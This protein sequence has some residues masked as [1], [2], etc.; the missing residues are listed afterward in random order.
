VRNGLT[1]RKIQS[2]ESRK[3]IF[4]AAITLIKKKGFDEVTIE[5]ICEKAKVSKGL[6]YNYFESKDQII[7]DEFLEI[8]NHYRKITENKFKETKGIAKLL[9][10]IHE[11]DRF[12]RKSMGKDLLRNVYRSLITKHDYTGDAILQKERYFYK[13]LVEIAQEAQEAGEIRRDI[14]AEEVADYIAILMRG[15]FYNFCLYERGFSYKKVALHI[16]ST[17][18]AGLRSTT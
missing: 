8:D 6:F 12:I 3:K 9:G 5:E 17:Y 7:R 1:K 10:V 4:D 18:V 2:L 11:Q 13:L 14:P 16:I 15:V